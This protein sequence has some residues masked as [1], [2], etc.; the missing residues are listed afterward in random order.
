MRDHE[1]KNINFKQSNYEKYNNYLENSKHT[2]LASA[3]YDHN[4]MHNKNNYSNES[5]SKPSCES[6]NSNR[7]SLGSRQDK[8]PRALI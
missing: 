3:V 7:N 6:K 4:Y 8:T 1:N 2:E 5:L